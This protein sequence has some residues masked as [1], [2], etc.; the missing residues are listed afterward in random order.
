MIE[1]LLWTILSVFAVYQTVEILHHSTAGE[2]W[3]KCS[4]YLIRK[5]DTATKRTYLAYLGEGMQCP[6]CYSNWF[7]ILYVGLWSF[8]NYSVVAAIAVA[9]VGGLAVARI[10]NLIN[11][12]THDWCRTP[13]KN[14][15]SGS[16][17]MEQTLNEHN[18]EERENN[19]G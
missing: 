7:G 15:N 18:D 9:F 3:R 6:F 4:N 13:N 17:R 19:S 12:A 2:Y 16:L 1:L 10:A 5:T 14:E 8:Y 11:D